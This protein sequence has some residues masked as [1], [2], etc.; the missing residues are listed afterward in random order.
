MGRKWN[1]VHFKLRDMR[2]N[3]VRIKDKTS[4]TVQVRPQGVTRT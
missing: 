1:V 3:S 2:L 4:D